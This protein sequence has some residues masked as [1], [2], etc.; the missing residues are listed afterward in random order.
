MSVGDVKLTVSCPFPLIIESI[1][2][3]AGVV[4]TVMVTGSTTSNPDPSVTVT[5]NE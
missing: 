1:V 5:F 4:V 2:G 3:A